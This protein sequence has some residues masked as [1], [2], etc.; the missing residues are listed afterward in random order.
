MWFYQFKKSA[1][2]LREFYS[3]KTLILDLLRDEWYGR[4]NEK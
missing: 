2:I 4:A 3:I 1:Y